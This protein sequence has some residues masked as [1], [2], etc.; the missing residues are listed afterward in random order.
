MNLLESISRLRVGCVRL[1]KLVGMTHDSVPRYRSH[2]LAEVNFAGSNMHPTGLLFEKRR[3]HPFNPE[4]KAVVTWRKTSK[5]ERVGCII[6]RIKRGRESNH[7]RAHL[8]MNVAKD[9]GNAFSWKC[10]GLSCSSLVKSKIKTFPIEEREDIVKERICIGKLNNRI[11][12]DDLE[13]RKEHAILLKQGVLLVGR[14]RRR[15]RPGQWL[16]PKDSGHCAKHSGLR[17]DDMK[18]HFSHIIL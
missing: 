6:D 16:Q 9:I 5:S 12:R 3:L 10:Y 1:S 8:R 2:Y 11:Y 17:G 18:P 15:G 4:M 14:K 13:V 7:H